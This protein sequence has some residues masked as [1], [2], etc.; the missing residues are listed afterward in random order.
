ME[1][2]SKYFPS[3]ISDD[4]DRISVLYAPFRD[5]TVNPKGYEAKLNTWQDAVFRYLREEKAVYFDS[6]D[7]VQAFSLRDKNPLCLNEVLAQ[8]TLSKKLVTEDDFYNSLQ[9]NQKGGAKG[10]FFPS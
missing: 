7:V 8:M 10:L 1:A 3:E 4:P 6:E 2:I 5:K 9:A